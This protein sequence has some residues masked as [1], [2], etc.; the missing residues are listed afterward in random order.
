MKQSL[1][2]QLRNGRIPNSL[3]FAGPEGVGKGQFALELARSFVCRN[4]NGPEA[5]G[6]CGAC[7]RSV[8]FNIPKADKRDDFRQVFFSEH[9]DVGAVVPYNKNIL[10]DAVRDLEREANLRPYEAR[11]RLFVID[12]ADK[13][14]DAASNALLKTLEEPPAESHIVLISSRPD[15]LLQTILSRCQIVR[16]APISLEEIETYLT[17]TGK[18]SPDDARLAARL[19]AGSIGRALSMA[20]DEI[21]SRRNA[22]MQVL[23]SV[24]IRGDRAALLAASETLADA[25]N[26]DNFETG[27]EILESLIHDVWTLKL[28]AEP[29]D[30]ANSDLVNHLSRFAGQ[31]RAPELAGWLRQIELL[32]GRTEVN[33]NKRIATDALFMEMASR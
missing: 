4:Q 6:K 32:R 7:R 25:K 13:M 30:I 22:M 18:F 24:F 16:F 1:R 23:E 19:S 20:P 11:A 29:Q 3:L 28:A 26:R 12:D 17:A 9:P 14:N 5:C 31:A 2:R 15:S 21:R 27:L 10:V 8:V 33:I